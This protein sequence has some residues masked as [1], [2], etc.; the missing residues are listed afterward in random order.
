MV[1]TDTIAVAVGLSG[2]GKSTAMYYVALKLALEQKYEIIIVYNPEDMRQLYNP[3]CKQVFVVDDVLSNATL[4][5]YKAKKWSD[6]SNNI[7]KI[8]SANQ[9]KI[10]ASCKTHIFQHRIDKAID[11]L[12][13][14]SCDFLS[15]DYCLTDDERENIANLYLTKDEISDLKSSNNLSKFDF[16]Q[17]FV[18]IILN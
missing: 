1:N 2:C 11:I 4:D 10:L 8:I 14:F 13:D 5:E 18:D 15:N 3:D 9:A 7:K 6:M 12:S 16:F 17:F